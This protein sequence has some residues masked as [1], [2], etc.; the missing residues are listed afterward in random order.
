[1]SSI[2]EALPEPARDFLRSLQVERGLSRS[3]IEA[4][5]NDLLLF[6]EHL[7]SENVDPAAP[8]SI[9]SRQV[10][11]F[12]RELHRRGMSRR[13]MARKLSTL[14]GFFRFCQKRG[15]IEAHP[16]H[17]LSNPKQEAF[18]PQVLNVDN[19][20]ALLESRLDRDPKGLR[21]MAL[22]ELLYGSGLRISE[23]LQLD[24]QDFDPAE[25][26]I[27]IKGK[28]G[29]ERLAPLTEAGVRRLKE[30][31]RQRQAFAPKPKEMALF[32]GLRGKRLQRRQANR[33]IEG[34]ARAAGLP[35]HISPHA[36]RHSFATH[37]L[38]A[39]AD[40]RTVQELLGHSR[41]STTQRY[42]HLSLGSL[43]TTYDRCHPKSEEQK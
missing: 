1:M 28:G 5:G 7:S 2:D 13:T 11:T 34:L 36:L 38:E 32:L 35:Q 42:T 22:A 10:H 19:V 3:T 9:T 8:R 12:L 37:L 27:R 14:R 41:L 29:K 26:I 20:L 30:Y 6:A 39:G 17:G 4:Y 43:T 25:G 15:L 24:L 40:L 31:L 21:D 16:M 18:H 33:I 23:A